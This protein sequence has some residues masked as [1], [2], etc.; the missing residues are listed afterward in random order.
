MADKIRIGIIGTGII[1]KSH[2]SRYQS[3]PEAEIAAVCDIQEA[4]A[5]KVAE[6]N[7]VAKVFTDYHD[8]LAID[9]IDA[10]DVC[11]HNQ[12]HAPATIAAVKA[13]KHVYCEKP[14]A[15]AYADAKA[16]HDA[17]RAAGKK[18]SI[19]LATLFQGPSRAAKRLIDSG[20][21]GELYYAKSSFYR[22]RGRPF[23]DGYA[24]PAF[25]QTKAAGGGALL[26]MAVYHISLIN[27][28]L[29]NPKVVTV[30]GSVYQK[31]GMYEE[32]RK[33]SG[34]DVEELGVGLVRY[35]NGI[36]LFIEEAWAIHMDKGTGARVMGSKAGVCVDPFTYFTTMSDLE[37]NATVD[38]DMHEKRWHSCDP[39]A[40]G[41]DSPQ[42][43]WIYGLLGRVDL[44]DTGSIALTTAQITE[45]LYKSAKLGREVTAEEI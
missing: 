28:L 39:D 2:I 22:R 5:K 40:I 13:G 30:S 19:Q 42:H 4:E 16:M 10:V 12:L 21:L 32:R 37:M 9:E 44:I 31:T 45:G 8:L 36:T 3:I 24:T 34:Y 26:D 25:V 41:F 11:L 27:W 43:N 6:V 35:E 33:E 17:A 20:H 23:V 15:A 38:V 7:S 14:M 1:G 29:G 18:L